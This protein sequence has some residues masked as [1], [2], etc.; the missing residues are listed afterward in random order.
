MFESPHH[1]NQRHK[2]ESDQKMENELAALQRVWQETLVRIESVRNQER[3]SEILYITGKEFDDSEPLKKYL[4]DNEDH[5]L[6]EEKFLIQLS[7]LIKEARRKAADNSVEV[8]H[9]QTLSESD[10]DTFVKTGRIS[11]Q[12]LE[13]LAKKIIERKTLTPEEIAVYAD[14][15]SE[16]EKLLLR[17]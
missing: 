10:Y 11:N 14:K 5:L 3:V 17:N 13:V 8:E 9:N 1:L 6:P 12:I 7:I 2:A 15:S 16:I 4:Q